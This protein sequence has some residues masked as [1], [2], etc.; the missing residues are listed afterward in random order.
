MATVIMKID[1]V[2]SARRGLAMGLNEAGYL[3]VAVTAMATGYL[4]RAMVCGRR[5]SCS[6][7][8]TRA[9]PRPVDRG[10]AGDPC[11]FTT[12]PEGAGTA[13]TADPGS[14]STRRVSP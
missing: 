8:H 11:M 6:A 7:L 9:R 5:R 3:A 2:G 1:L 4:A 13:S 12:R 10:G 14:L